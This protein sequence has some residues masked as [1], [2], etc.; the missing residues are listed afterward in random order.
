M[1]CVSYQDHAVGLKKR[2]TVDGDRLEEVRLKYNLCDNVII[3]KIYTKLRAIS[4]AWPCTYRSSDRG[5]SSEEARR[6]D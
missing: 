1:S 2:V 6:K 3:Y 4:A 5:R